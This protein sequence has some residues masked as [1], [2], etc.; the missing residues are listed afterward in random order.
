MGPLRDLSSSAVDPPTPRSF[1]LPTQRPY[2]AGFVEFYVPYLCA[3]SGAASASGFLTPATSSPP[4]IRSYY[5]GWADKIHGKTI[6]VDG[7]FM[8]YTLHEPIGV[9]GQVS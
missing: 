1:Q 2:N 8:A 6:P 3:V 9:V 4:H 5:A 7:P